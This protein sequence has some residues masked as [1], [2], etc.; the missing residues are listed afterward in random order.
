MELY[1]QILKLFLNKATWL[2]YN[3]AIDKV[4]LKDNYPEVY[5][6][7]RTLDILQKDNQGESY[8]PA[9]LE[10]G[11]LTLYPATDISLYRSLFHSI[12]TPTEGE[13]VPI[14]QYLVSLRTR[15]EASRLGF[16]ALDVAE[17][18][19]EKE[20]LDAAIGAFSI[21]TGAVGVA[22]DRE[23]FVVSK[24]SDLLGRAYTSGG[25]NWRLNSLNRALGPLRRGDMGF[26]FARPESGKTTFLASE[27]THF[28][29]QVDKPILWFN[30][31]EQGEKVMLRCYEASLKAPLGKIIAQKDKADELFFERTKGRIHLKDDA[32]ISRQDIE[33]LCS[34]FQPSLI[35]FDQI[36]KIKGFDADRDDLK[37]GAIYQWARELA[38]TYAP[39]IGVCQASGE[40]D[41]V[42]WLNMNHVALAK[43][44]KQAEADWIL[45]IGTAF[46]DPPNVRG[47]S[48]CKNKLLGGEM[49]VPELRH[50]HW[51]VLIEPE[52]ARYTD[53]A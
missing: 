47:F 41:G 42:K 38:K 16:I 25:L 49:T 40:A 5:K 26:I 7:F 46:T 34:R 30:N 20:A 51:E 45:G 9:D 52:V 11:L 35:I 39:V 44:S 19:K 28:A 36:D 31:E 22:E 48:L 10:A 53:V 14:R 6:L 32:N 18:K 1:V 37:L 15:Q 33:R 12:S 3:E 27:A 17:G 29:K 23:D 21:H 50:G 4:F 24:L 8:S 43:T 13:S 2:E